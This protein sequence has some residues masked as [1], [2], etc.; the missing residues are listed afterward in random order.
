MSFLEVLIATLALIALTAVTAAYSYGRFAR[1]TSAPP[2]HALPPADADTAIDRAL[3]PLLTAHP[4]LDGVVLL[5]EGAQA[6]AARALT[7][8][9]A[10]RSLDLQY[11]YWRKDTAGRLLMREIVAAA[12][13]G[14]RVRLLIDDINTRGNDSSY[15]ELDAHPGI[16]VRL[17]NP[18]RNRANG[19]R[20]GLELALRAFRV[21]RRMHNKAWIAD[22]RLAII[23]G[24]NI[25]NAYFNAAQTSNFHDLD[26]LVAG[27]AVA[28]AETIFDRFW[29]SP[30]AVPIASLSR[31]IARRLPSRAIPPTAR[32][33]ANV[34]ALPRIVETLDADAALAEILGRLR[35][36]AEVQILSDP[37][38]KALG[39]GAEGWLA[40][41][42]YRAIAETRSELQITSPY[43]IPGERGL[44]ALSALV[45]R[46][47]KVTVLTN[48]LAATDVVAVHGAYAGYRKRL[49]QLGV[50][51]YELRPE[52]M[53]A[54]VS[55]FGS[56]GASL[57]TK[58]FTV[59]R[60]TGF[61]GSFNFDPR[62]VSLNTEM[63]V[64]VVDDG[65]VAEMREIF[66]RET[67]PHC[68]FRLGLDRD[69]LC[70]H[71]GSQRDGHLQQ[72]PVAGFG[73]RLTA[74]LVRLLPIE[75]QL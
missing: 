3:G 17:F 9:S 74:A 53:P 18:S 32:D 63:G 37:P 23:G 24:R 14:V 30:T 38:E 35:W 7:A 25:G 65:L 22:G 39:A 19:I 12:D 60:H 59:D 16:E 15:L 43:F 8:R 41:R 26:L 27:E 48:S 57:H 40:R 66:A 10:G 21:T 75:S 2:S 42:L 58:A 5:S 46:G 64:V 4:G 44:K 28:Q 1:H 62:S 50:E 31:P 11:Y 36:V 6:F 68:S 20:R 70:W 67:A 71:A 47:A 45:A 49:L 54:G 13:R 61:V 69:R 56:K 29:N 51:L 55:L 73:R 52:L 72:E 34:A 33:R